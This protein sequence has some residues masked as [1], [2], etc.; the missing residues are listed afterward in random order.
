MESLG[1]TSAEAEAR[2]VEHGV[3]ALPSEK[4]KNLLQ[5]AFSVLREPMLLLL[6]AAGAISF[7]LAEL[8]DALLLMATVFIVLGISIYQERRT[9]RALSALR[10]LTAP[11]ALVI[12]DGKEQRIGSSQIVPGDLLVL[13]EGDRIAAIQF[14]SL[15][16]RSKLMSRC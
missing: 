14:W 1:L 8:V 7:L 11:L 6:A 2:L 10:E 13:L 4:E 5:V 3:N 15:V 16:R 9:E 12:R